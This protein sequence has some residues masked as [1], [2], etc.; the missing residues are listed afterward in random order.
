MTE[1]EEKEG[2]ELRKKLGERRFV[3]SRAT[4]EHKMFY[5]FTPLLLLPL[6]DKSRSLEEEECSNS[7]VHHPRNK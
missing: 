6:A 7:N 1:E 3:P 4:A 2:N 5:I